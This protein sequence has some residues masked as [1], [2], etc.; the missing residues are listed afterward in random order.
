MKAVHELETSGAPHPRT[1]PHFCRILFA[2]VLNSALVP[3]KGAMERNRVITPADR[4]GVTHTC[5]V[6]SLPPV[7]CHSHPYSS[8]QSSYLR[9]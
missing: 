3:P 8:L 4:Q 2:F 6:D 7:V 9:F 1:R 5:P